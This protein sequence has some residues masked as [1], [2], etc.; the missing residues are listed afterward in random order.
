[1][2]ALQTRRLVW[3]ASSQDR[4]E[5]GG[6]HGVYAFLALPK[7]TSGTF[8]WKVPLSR[9]RSREISFFRALPARAQRAPLLHCAFS[10]ARRAKSDEIRN[11]C[12]EAGGERR[13]Q[14]PAALPGRTGETALENTRMSSGQRLQGDGWTWWE[15][16]REPSVTGAVG[17]CSCRPCLESGLICAAGK[18][19]S[20]GCRVFDAT[21]IMQDCVF[22]GLY[23]RRGCPACLAKVFGGGR[24]SAELQRC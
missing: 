13:G 14:W 11:I 3:E 18:V 16:P 1:M 17:S 4:V 5:P 12:A 9:E 6:I 19:V 20:A 24:C 10:P 21:N 15:Q 8:G 2:R 22:Y 23:F 7:T